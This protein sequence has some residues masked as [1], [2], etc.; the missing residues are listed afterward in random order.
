MERNL[1]VISVNVSEK[2]GTIKKPVESIT[3]TNLGIEGDAHS[4]NWNRQISLLST[5]SI[6]E[7]SQKSERVYVAGEFAENITLSGMKMS[8]CHPGDIL[9]CRDLELMVTQ[10]GKKCHGGGCS[11][12][13]E[14]GACVMPKEGIFAKVL[15]AGTLKPGD[16]LTFKRRRYRAAVITVSTRAYQG[17]YQDLSGQKA[18]LNLQNFAKERNI[19]LETALT[20]IP[21]NIEAIKNSVEKY[22]IEGFDFIFTTGGT[23]IGPFDYTSNIIEGVLEIKIPGIMEH[24]RTKYGAEK[25]NALLSRGVAGYAKETFI[26]TMPGSVNAVNEYMCEILPLLLHM[27]Y[28][29]MGLDTH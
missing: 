13:Q 14:T 15:K 22:M 26:A 19:F 23:G 21:D 12:F 16:V 29:R 17:V 8:D 18:I 7:F 1:K 2:K 25:P 5:E 24:I 6:E 28:M 27:K 11:I 20:L 4:G 3:I 10:I 9:T